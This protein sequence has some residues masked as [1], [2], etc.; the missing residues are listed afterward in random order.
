[1]GGGIMM[2][3]CEIEDASSSPPP[4]IPACPFCIH[5]EDFSWDSTPD[6][7]IVTID[8]VDNWDCSLCTNINGTYV[9]KHDPVQRL[10]DCEYDIYLGEQLFGCPDGPPPYTPGDYW[11]VVYLKISSNR[12]DVQIRKGHIYDVGSVVFGTWAVFLTPTIDCR[13]EQVLTGA[14]G[15]DRCVITGSTATITPVCYSHDCSPP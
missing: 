4:R 5:A 3:C 12:I 8:G 2:C 14:F 10:T 13:D 11:D 7:W 6:E 9:L 1:M 15:L